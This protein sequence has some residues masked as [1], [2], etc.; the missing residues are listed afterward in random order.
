MQ[1]DDTF[2]RFVHHLTDYS[3]Q[4]PN[5]Y[6]PEAIFSYD[7]GHSL[8][9]LE[10]TA[11]TKQ[12]LSRMHLLRRQKLL[13]L[14]FFRAHFVK[15]LPVVRG[16]S[17]L[18]GAALEPCFLTFPPPPQSYRLARVVHTLYS[19]LYVSRRHF[20]ED[21]ISPSQPFDGHRYDNVFFAKYSYC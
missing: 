17:V 5:Q 21:H 9:H 13:R 8:V 11:S 4:I 12:S 7:H 18:A 10:H 1:T 6:S 20:N 15:I 3:A 2:P 19:S 14:H 16:N